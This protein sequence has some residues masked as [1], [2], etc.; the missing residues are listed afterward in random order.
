MAERDATTIFSYN[1]TRFT[2]EPSGLISSLTLFGLGMV[3]SPVRSLAA[4]LRYGLF[5]VI[6]YL[7]ATFTH[8]LGHI[9]SSRYAKAPMDQLHLSAPMPRT[10]YYNNNVPPRAHRMRAIGGWIGSTITL[11]VVL[12]LRAFTAPGT[13][14]RQFLNVVSAF[15]ALIGFGSL[16]PLPFIDGGTL[17]KWTLVERGNS[18]EEADEVVQQANLGVGGLLG[19]IGLFFAL[20]RQWKVALGLFFGAVQFIAVGL[21]KVKL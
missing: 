10:V 17:L 18:P 7:L 12:L 6:G 11:V 4:R 1:E 15:Q 8:S 5:M 20:R 14:L 16:A 9:H 3:I 19:A 21:G 2:A 13:V